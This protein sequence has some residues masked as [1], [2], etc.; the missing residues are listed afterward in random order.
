MKSINKLLDYEPVQYIKE[1]EAVTKHPVI[2]TDGTNT[3]LKITTNEEREVIATKAKSFLKLVNGK[4]IPVNGDSLKVGDYL[5][6]STKQIDFTENFEMCVRDIL[7]PT[8]Y[9]YSSEVEKAKKVMH[10]FHW[11]SKHQVNL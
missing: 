11:W 3:M 5:P 4:I 2:N 9:I 8:E 6:V 1:I 10:E 7:P